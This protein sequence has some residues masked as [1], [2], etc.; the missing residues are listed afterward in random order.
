MVKNKVNSEKAEEKLPNHTPS[1]F[2]KT[3]NIINIWEGYF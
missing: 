1:T 3:I 2:Y